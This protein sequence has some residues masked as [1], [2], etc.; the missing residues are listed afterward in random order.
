MNRGYFDDEYIIDN[1]TVNSRL[2]QIGRN[3]TE[4]EKTLSFLSSAKNPEQALLNVFKLTFCDIETDGEYTETAKN[5]SLNILAC[6]T[7]TKFFLDSI[8]VIPTWY[9]LS[10]DDVNFIEDLIQKHADEIGATDIPPFFHELNDQINREME[11][12]GFAHDTRTS[13]D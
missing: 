3:Q 10:K 1:S 8:K 11:K 7:G 9:S 2:K 12:R 13:T 6:I 5:I 4:V